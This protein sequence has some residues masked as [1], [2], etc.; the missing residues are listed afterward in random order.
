MIWVYNI[1]IEK[2]WGKKIQNLKVFRILAALGVMK[3]PIPFVV[4][5]YALTFFTDKGNKICEKCI[6]KSREKCIEKS[7]EI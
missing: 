3:L 2:K 5:N 1:F 6:E 4:Q 7:R